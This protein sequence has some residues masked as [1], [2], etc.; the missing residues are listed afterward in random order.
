MFNFTT[1]TPKD[2]NTTTATATSVAS[3]KT[4]NWLLNLQNDDG[5]DNK[6]SESDETASTTE[7]PS[8]D[9]YKRTLFFFH[10]N[11]SDLHNRLDCPDTKFHRTYNL[12]LYSLQCLLIYVVFYAYI[13]AYLVSYT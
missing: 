10:A 9:R 5:D 4:P 1:S 2:K 3:T 13:Y 7:L 11:S 12:Y 8:G 6:T